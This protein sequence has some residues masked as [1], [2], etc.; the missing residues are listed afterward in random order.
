[1][2]DIDGVL[3]DVRHRVHHV[4]R[5]PKDWDA[6]FAAAPDDPPL[7]EGI[8]LVHELLRS[9][10][11]IAYVSG[12]PERCRD[13]TVRWLGEHGLPPAPLHLRRDS[14]RRPARLT[15]AAVIRGLQGSAPVAVVVDDDAAVVEAL[16]A[17]GLEV[18]HATW[19]GGGTHGV[20]SSPAQEALFEAQELDGRT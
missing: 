8:A 9:G 14:D 19:M 5:R 6:F 20:D 1:V 2:I 17:A 15:K 12:R 3:A 11:A 7:P 13:D 18:L 16:R 4:E 10:H